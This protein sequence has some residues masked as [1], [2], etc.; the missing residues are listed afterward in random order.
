[1]AVESHQQTA[2]ELG[3]QLSQ[4]VQR[5]STA[6]GQGDELLSSVRCVFAALQVAVRDEPVDEATDRGETDAKLARECC[7]AD[8]GSQ[9]R[10]VQDLGL[11]HGHVDGQELVGVAVGHVAHQGSVVI[12]DLLLDR[13]W[14]QPLLSIA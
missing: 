6:H 2:H 1:M 8:A 10:D 13:T 11:R 4:V 7:H 12:E 14:A 3:S 9:R 5:L